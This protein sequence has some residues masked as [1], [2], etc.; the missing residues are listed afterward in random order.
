MFFSN[1]VKIPESEWIEIKVAYKMLR[2]K[3]LFLLND[4]EELEK[5]NEQ[6]K[7]ELKKYRKKDEILNIWGNEFNKIKKENEQFKKENEQLKAKIKKTEEMTKLLLQK[8]DEYQKIT[9]KIRPAS[10]FEIFG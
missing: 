1:Y 5:E 4:L 2:N 10:K 6:L 9:P 8:L 3:N 7:K